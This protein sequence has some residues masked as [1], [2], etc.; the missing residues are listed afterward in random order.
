[1]TIVERIVAGLA[2]LAGKLA[3]L[4]A[5]LCLAL[6]GTGVGM[7]YFAHAPQSWID[8]T[9]TWTVIA[10]VLLAAPMAQWRD[11][12][13]GVDALVLRFGPHGRRLLALFSA[14][15]VA[16]VG[17]LMLWAGIETVSFSQMI[18]IMANTLAWMP[19]WI[20]QSLLPIGGGLLML[21]A[22]AQLLTILRPGWTPPKSDDPV[23]GTR[24]H[25]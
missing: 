1:M 19:M 16:M 20:V 3:G 17:A 22:L 23:H 25:E 10:M 9:A 6:V 11:E 18:G 2:S 21:T 15:T 8:E 12:H 5:L 14:I 24:S 4:M 7:R 13:I